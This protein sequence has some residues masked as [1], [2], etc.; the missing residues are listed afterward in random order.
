MKKQSCAC[1]DGA[2]NRLQAINFQRSEHEDVLSPWFGVGLK[3]GASDC[4]LLENIMSQKMLGWFDIKFLK[5][6]NLLQYYVYIQSLL[7]S[8]QH[9]SAP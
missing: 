5:L 9:S 7:R 2:K 4:V 3:E 1:D 8:E 6:I